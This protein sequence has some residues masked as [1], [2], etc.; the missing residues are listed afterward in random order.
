[1]KKTLLALAA[2]LAVFALTGCGG[3]YSKEVKG[4]PDPGRVVI[5]ENTEII[6]REIGNTTIYYI[7]DKETKTCIAQTERVGPWWGTSSVSIAMAPP[8]ACGFPSTVGKV[9]VV[10]MPPPQPPVPPKSQPTKAA[11]PKKAASAAPASCL[12]CSQT[13]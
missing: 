13:P 11:A 2:A 4:N 5:V 1:M 6:K 3:S 8:E 12:V 7:G 9:E 10:N